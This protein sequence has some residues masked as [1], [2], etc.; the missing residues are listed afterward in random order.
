MA[1]DPI[2]F[3]QHRI[4]RERLLAEKELRNQYTP[5][6]PEVSVPSTV[7]EGDD[8]PAGGARTFEKAARKA[9]FQTRVT[10]SRGIM[11]GLDGERERVLVKAQR[12]DGAWVV[13]AWTTE[14]SGDWKAS[15]AYI[16]RAGVRTRVSIKEA[17]AWMLDVPYTWKGFECNVC[18]QVS[19]YRARGLCVTC[20][21]TARRNDTLIDHPRIFKKADDVLDD[22]VELVAQGYNREQIADRLEMKVNTLDKVIQRGRDRG[23]ARADAYARRVAIQGASNGRRHAGAE[24]RAA[25]S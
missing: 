23:D 8:I 24:R 7:V 13:V 6:E 16:P 14:L 5:F 2:D 12:E 4:D 19:A 25:Q 1:L 22:F 21:D 3:K 11:P 9:G 20:Y 15:F 17:K 10:Y 18:H